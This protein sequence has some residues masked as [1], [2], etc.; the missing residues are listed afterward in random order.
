MITY[1]V[2]RGLFLE[3]AVFL[4]WHHFQP[5][6]ADIFGIL[7]IIIGVVTALQ[8]YFESVAIKR[9]S[10][11]KFKARNGIPLDQP[12]QVDRVLQMGYFKADR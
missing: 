9:A 1:R 10:I 8:I 11:A 12:H 2:Y 5:I 4:V 6:Y 7:M 3:L